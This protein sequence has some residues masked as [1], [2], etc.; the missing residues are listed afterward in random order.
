MSIFSKLRASF[1]RSGGR[2]EPQGY[3]PSTQTPIIRVSICTGERVAGFKDVTGHFTEVM[4]IRSDNDLEE[5]KRI[6]N[7]DDLPTEY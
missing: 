2:F 4:L 5:F 1:E 7:V 3:A 6:Y